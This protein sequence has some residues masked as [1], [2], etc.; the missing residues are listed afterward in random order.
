MTFGEKDFDFYQIKCSDSCDAKIRELDLGD[1]KCISCDDVVTRGD[2]K[3]VFTVLYPLIGKIFFEEFS[4]MWGKLKKRNHFEDLAA[5][6]PNLPIEKAFFKTFSKNK[7]GTLPK[8]TAAYLLIRNQW[9]GFEKS[10]LAVN[11]LYRVLR[12]SGFKA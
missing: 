12:C 9:P 1:V 10:I 7:A 4:A 11:K 2:A 6:F 3:K 5:A 8:R